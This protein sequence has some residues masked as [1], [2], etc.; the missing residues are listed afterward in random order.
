MLHILGAVYYV[1]TIGSES[2][3]RPRLKG[4][5]LACPAKRGAKAQNS[6][7]GIALAIGAH[8]IPVLSFPDSV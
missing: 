8:V 6:R 4:V 3:N 7:I 1:D 2:G 5:A